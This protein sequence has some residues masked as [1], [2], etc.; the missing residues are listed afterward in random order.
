LLWCTVVSID[1]SQVSDTP[2]ANELRRKYI[3]KVVPM[4]NPD[5]VANGSH[6]CSLAVGWQGFRQRCS[7]AL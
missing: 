6:R 4:L 2:I 5:G 3:F 1:D 7:V